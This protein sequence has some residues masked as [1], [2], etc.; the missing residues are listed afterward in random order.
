MQIIHR[1]IKS[2]NILVNDKGDVKLSDFG[3]SC[4][5]NEKR[6]RRNSMVGTVCWMAPELVKVTQKGYDSAIDIWSFGIFAMELTNGD[7]PYI[8]EPQHR[9]IMNIVKR[10]PPPLEERWSSI[11][12]DFVDKTL[13]KDPKQRWTADQLLQ[14]EFLSD[15]M[16]YKEEFGQVVTNFCVLRDEAK[17]RRRKKK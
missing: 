3:F 1:D 6:V 17:A 10:N 16:N 11:F 5:L 8:S 15:A 12:Q 7:P 9:V 4:Q 2:D 13:I 14:H